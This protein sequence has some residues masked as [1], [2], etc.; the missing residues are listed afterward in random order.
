[1]TSSGTSR[2]AFVAITFAA[3]AFLTLAVTLRHEPWCDE[4]DSWLLMRDG[5]VSTMLS[6]TGYAGTP[7]LWYLLIAPLAR[8]GLPY[9]AQALLNLA[10]AWAAVLVFL[11]WSPF[12]RLA[13]VLFVFSYFAA[14]EYAVLARPYALMLLLLFSIAAMWARRAEHPVAVAIAAALLANTTSHGLIIA[15][16]LGAVLLADAIAT[17]SLRRPAV[18]LALGLIV[19]GGALAALQ[20]RV[21]ADGP[22][23]VRYVDPQ[24]LPY[25]IGS[26]FLPGFDPRP[27]FA[28]SLTALICIGIAVARRW[29]AMLFLSLSLALLLALFVFVWLGGLRHAGLILVLAIAA[30]WMATADEPGAPR[31]PRAEAVAIVALCVTL[32]LSIATA[33]RSSIDDWRFA[34]SG[35]EEMGR[36]IR[37]RNLDRLEIAA[38]PPNET[39]SVLVFLPGKRFWF[40]ATAAYGSYST[41]DRTFDR[42]QL[43]PGQ[44][45]VEA[46]RSQLAGRDWL[47][48]TNFEVA[49]KDFQLLFANGGRISGRPTERFFL[50]R[51]LR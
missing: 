3:Y 43:T 37:E 5:G 26:A 32:G 18:I 40:P 9:E 33:A 15:F 46:A 23:V 6:R 12:P 36:F 25:A 50:Y 51:P 14:Y 44:T 8:A 29:Q 22:R 42:A 24:S 2:R 34:Y 31:W 16:V 19:A 21:P 1:M 13:Q 49:S 39:K 30:L 11:V 27:W 20:L 7:A 45:A 28:V 17:K 4:A 48:L 10:L 35:G 38:H 47:L 41:W